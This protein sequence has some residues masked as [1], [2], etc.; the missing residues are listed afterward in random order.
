MRSQRGA[1]A[2]EMAVVAPILLLLVFGI[3]ES[4]WL[5]AQQVELNNAAREGARLAV[6]DYGTA[7]EIASETC[8]RTA[9]SG[10]GATVT[11][12]RSV[13]LDPEVGDPPGTPESVT[14][15]MA[16]NYA[17]LTGFLDPI[18]DGLAMS[19]TVEMRT[20]RPLETL[21]ADGGGSCP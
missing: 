2:V 15:T 19:S 17:S 11:V 4:G 7:A 9:L 1:A 6:V 18:F 8:A 14:V 5:F 3:M 13:V 21:V 12:T 10:G 20:E 16:N